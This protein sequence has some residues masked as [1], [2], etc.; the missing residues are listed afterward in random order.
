MNSEIFKK[1]KGGPFS[2]SEIP[3][4][5]KHFG[6]DPPSPRTDSLPQHSVL[7]TTWLIGARKPL[8][9]EIAHSTLTHLYLL[10][11]LFFQR[12]K[13]F[14]IRN[15]LTQQNQTVGK[16][17]GFGEW[18]RGV[19]L[20]WRR[21]L[22]KKWRH[23]SFLKTLIKEISCEEGISALK[24]PSFIFNIFIL[25]CSFFFFFFYE[26]DLQLSKINMQRDDL[27]PAVYF[28]ALQSDVRL[29]IPVPSWKGQKWAERGWVYA[30][31]LSIIK[32]ILF[33]THLYSVLNRRIYGNTVF[34]LWDFMKQRQHT[35][36]NM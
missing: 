36:R 4:G 25:L 12:I 14:F 30:W 24:V 28:L 16:A 33:I 34:Y 11:R 13:M 18:G 8:F 23:D 22:L 3:R 9:W 6:I 19:F 31:L 17:W 27:S 26:D 21:N 1:Y 15:I 32:K 10:E 5:W 20:L 35:C 2:P 7:S 29:Q